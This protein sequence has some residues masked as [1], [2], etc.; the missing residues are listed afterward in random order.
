MNKSTITELYCTWPSAR[1]LVQA[2]IYRP[3]IPSAKVFLFVSVSCNFI[4]VL[5]NGYN[6]TESTAASDMDLDPLCICFAVVKEASQF[7]LYWLWYVLSIRTQFAI[8]TD[9]GQESQCELGRRRGGGG[10]TSLRRGSPPTLRPRSFE[11][12]ACSAC[13][14]FY[15]STGLCHCTRDL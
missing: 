6:G 10:S 4:Y 15:A 11:G 5:L 9:A 13:Y 12:S 3:R 14:D 7:R 1:P 2:Y 8:R